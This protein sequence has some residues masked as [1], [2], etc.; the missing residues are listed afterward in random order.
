MPVAIMGYV[1]RI[2]VIG[3]LKH[4]TWRCAAWNRFSPV[5]AE[6]LEGIVTVRAFS[7]ERRF[8]NDLHGK[9][10]M[11]TKISSVCT[12][13]QIPYEVCSGGYYCRFVYYEY[14]DL[15]MSVYWACRFWTALKLDLKYV[16]T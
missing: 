10:D 5:V 4:G 8:L 16:F 11:T 7:A 13:V 12:I 1:Y 3:Y 9:I 15:T 2:L 6:L 14:N